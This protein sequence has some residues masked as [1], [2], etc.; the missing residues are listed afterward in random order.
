MRRVSSAWRKARPSL[1][2][3]AGRTG[4][5]ARLMGAAPCIWPEKPIAVSPLSA[6]PP[7]LDVGD[8]AGQRR[9]QSSR[10]C[11]DHPT[12]GRSGEKARGSVATGSPHSSICRSIVEGHGG[13]LW[14]SA[15]CPGAPVFQFTLPISQDVSGAPD[16]ASR[17]GLQRSSVATLRQE[18]VALAGERQRLEHPCWRNPPLQPKSASRAYRPFMGP[19]SK[20]RKG[21]DL[22]RSPTRLE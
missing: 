7:N 11:S 13:R 2:R 8:G 19:T 18:A 14:A 15:I 20:V 5:S 22:R 10:F 21:S 4:L 9:G 1:C 3:I 16:A 6:L 12:R 17:A